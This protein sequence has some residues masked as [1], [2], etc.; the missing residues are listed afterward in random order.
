MNCVIDLGFRFLE[1]YRRSCVS[2]EDLSGR[3]SGVGS[4]MGEEA[5]SEGDNKIIFLPNSS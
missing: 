1:A 3:G 4:E 5:A 2:R